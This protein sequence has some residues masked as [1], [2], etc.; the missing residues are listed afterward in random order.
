VARPPALREQLWADVAPT[1]DAIL[2]HPFLT[3]VV[4]GTLPPARFA[5]FVVADVHFLGAFARALAFAAGHA[6]DPRDTALL[7]GAA[8]ASIQGEQEMHATFLAQAGRSAADL[9]A[10][11]P[12]PSVQLY[13]QTILAHTAQGPFP[14]ALVALLA[15]FWVYWEVGRRLIVQGSPQP[16]YQRWI[17]TYGDPDFGETVE[18]VLDAVDRVGAQVGDVERERLRAI[19]AQGCRLE[20]MF[21]DAAWREERWPIV[22]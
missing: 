13:I 19:F 15:C 8:V 3:G 21:W 2:R 10:S 4:D 14:R 6:D 20:W 18:A 7:T 11:E 9:E 5:H 1:F 12:S 16:R 17:D 22:A